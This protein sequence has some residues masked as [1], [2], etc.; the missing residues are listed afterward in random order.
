[1]ATWQDGNDI[2]AGRYCTP[3]VMGMISSACEGNAGCPCA[4][5]GGNPGGCPNSLNAAGAVL[6]GS[7]NPS[8]SG[9][10]VVLSGSG[11]PA[12]S[13]GLY[14]QGTT[15]IAGGGAVFGDG[16]RCAGGTVVRLGTKVATAGG[17][18]SYP[19]GSPAIHIKGMLPAGGGTFTYQ[20]WYRNAG[21]FCTP[22]TFNLT[23]GVVIFWIP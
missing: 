15:T 10:T 21:A 1:M 12:N 2:E 6:V 20:L 14:F 5:N 4:Q 22:S 13:P 9:D 19:S 3:T 11:M 8:I 16:K 23:N 7:G 18:S 17:A